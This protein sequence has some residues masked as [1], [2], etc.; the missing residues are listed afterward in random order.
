MATDDLFLDSDIPAGDIEF[1]IPAAST[2]KEFGNVTVRKRGDIFEIQLTLLIQPPA[3]MPKAWKTAVA[4]DASASMKKAFGRFLQGQI[5]AHVAKEYEEKGWFKKGYRDGR[6]VKTFA[7]PAVD[8][9]IKRAL[10]SLSPNHMDYLGPEFITY[11][12]RQ[13]DVD[14]APTLLYWAGEDGSGIELVGDIKEPDCAALTIEG[15]NEMAFGQKSF[16]LPAVKFLVDRVKNSHM[17]LFV[18]LTDGRIDDLPAVKEYSLALAREIVAGKREPIKCV[19]IGVGD[20]INE[21]PLSELD[22]LTSQTYI[23]LWDH[24]IVSDFQDM[25]KIFGELLRDA[26]I[27]ASKGALFDSSGKALRR[28]PNGLPSRLVFSM[29]ITSPWFELEIA[30]QRIRQLV[31][32]PKYGLGG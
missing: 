11:L 29:P 1:T 31:K 23:N 15:P 32:V 2:T 4:L 12:A 5:P 16:L 22:D 6:R 19:L 18:F 27:V 7:R 10:V 17:G 3:Q 26:Q 20:E 28:Y 21:A 8:D 13:M 25:L 9:A 24:M 30:D 14:R